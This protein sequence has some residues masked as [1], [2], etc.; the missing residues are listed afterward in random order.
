M[1]LVKG[2]AQYPFIKK[3]VITCTHLRTASISADPYATQTDPGRLL[4]YP[5][6]LVNG[7]A[8][9]QKDD[10]Q[11]QKNK[12]GFSQ[13]GTV[14]QERFL[15]WHENRVG[16]PGR[17]P[18]KGWLELSLQIVDPAFKLRCRVVAAHHGPGNHVSRACAGPTNGSPA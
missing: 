10:K 17:C 5:H 15:S 4:H 13:L 11:R 12:G 1:V 14:F 18:K 7:N 8:D 3:V 16:L 9:Q 2:N 6:R